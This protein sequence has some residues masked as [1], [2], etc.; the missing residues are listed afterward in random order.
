MT[1][2][3]LSQCDKMPHQYMNKILRYIVCLGFI[4]WTFLVIGSVWPIFIFFL[5]FVSEIGFLAIKMLFKCGNITKIG[6][7]IGCVSPGVLK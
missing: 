4:L 7:L 3:C 2:K 6:P 1:K 5:P